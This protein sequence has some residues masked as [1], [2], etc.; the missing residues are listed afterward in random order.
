[1]D[2]IGSGLA[3]SNPNEAAL[4]ALVNPGSYTVVL[5]GAGGSTGIGLVEIY[6]LDGSKR[7]TLANIATRGK[8]QGGDQVMIGGFIVLGDN[9]PTNVVVRGLGP[10][11]GAAGVAGSLADPILE[12]YDGN[13][14]LISQND[15]W[16]SGP[17]AGAIQ[18]F[19]LAPADSR[20]SAILLQNPVQGNYTAVLKGKN[21]GTGVSLVEAYVF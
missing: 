19:S 13:G 6:D 8:V 11:L 12:V 10:T 17:N 15:D 21:G 4:I 3:P 16:G 20:E 9:G 2:L 7:S 5:Q 1:V 18:G 14:R